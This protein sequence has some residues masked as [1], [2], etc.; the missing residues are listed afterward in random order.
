MEYKCSIC[1]QNKPASEFYPAYSNPKRSVGY[2]CKKCKKTRGRKK[3]SY[4]RALKKYNNVCGKCSW[5]CANKKCRKCLKEE[6]LQKCSKCLELL[7]LLISFYPNETTCK[8]CKAE[9][10][11]RRGWFGRNWAGSSR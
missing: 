10:R 9:L 2:Y 11:R 6:G 5:P 3:E 4:N 7:P 8:K 1:R